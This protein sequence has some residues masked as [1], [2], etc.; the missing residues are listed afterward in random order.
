MR[1]AEAKNNAKGRR[2]YSTAFGVIERKSTPGQ[3]QQADH[4]II[5]QRAE[6]AA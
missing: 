3:L 2:I 6:V 4:C 1:T 5:V